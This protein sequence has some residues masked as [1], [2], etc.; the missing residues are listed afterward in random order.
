MKRLT[1]ITGSI[2]LA[3]NALFGL[4]LTAY[5]TFN[6]GLNCVVIAA[7]TAL[8]YAMR[9]IRLRDGFFIPLSMLFAFFGFVEFVLGLFSPDKFQDN[10]YLIVVILLLVFEGVVLALTN[11]VSSRIPE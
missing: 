2:F 6:C 10:W 7:T 4:I 11:L 8:L 1:L 9:C 3:A 5:P